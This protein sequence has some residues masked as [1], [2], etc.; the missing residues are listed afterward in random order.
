MQLGSKA[1]EWASRT[2][3]ILS[4]IQGGLTYNTITIVSEDEA[5]SLRTKL[6]GFSGF[7]DK[8]S[9]YTS[10]ARMRSFPYSADDVKNI[11]EAK[12]DVERIENQ[13]KEMASFDASISYLQQALQYVPDSELRSRIVESKNKLE[14]VLQSD[15]ATID[16]FKQEL[17]SIK[18][19]YADWYL[20]QYLK[21]RI[22]DG[23]HTLKLALEES[24][25]MFIC[26]AL[27][28]ADFLSSAEF[29]A[30]VTNLSQLQ[31]A[32]QSV[33]IE[34]ILAAPYQDFNP[35]DYAG[36]TFFGIKELR[37]KL[38]DIKAD[39][40]DALRSTLEDPAVKKKL[41]LLSKEESNLLMAFKS[42]DIG[43]DRS[44]VRQIRDAI[45]NLHEGLQK[46]ELTLDALKSAFNK[47]LTPE[48]AM[49]AF[50]AYLDQI[51]VGKDRNKIRI[52]LK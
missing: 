44:N 34:L 3:T 16:A 45:M 8:L 18:Q 11:L 14:K 25:E 6:S 42:G 12:A 38:K 5:I 20:G 51:S 31:P 29:A 28:D 13:L 7:C 15:R 39:W 48:Q 2:V 36:K 32:K 35:L 10:E 33:N 1:T 40:E 9:S 4:K 50:K 24:D 27:K 43:L 47:P 23:D 26:N 41:E 52:I 49:E 19:D 21:F 22:S 17:D 46:V 37:A 30:L